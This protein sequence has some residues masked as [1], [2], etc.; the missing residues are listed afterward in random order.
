MIM[1]KQITSILSLIVLFSF[2]SCKGEDCLVI[3]KETEDIR[4]SLVDTTEVGITTRTSLNLDVN[5]FNV[6]LSR[7]E[8]QIFSNRKYKDI[9]GNTIS[10]S[11]TPGYVLTAENCNESEAESANLGW[12]QP[13]VRG[14]ETFTVIANE[15]TNVT[16]I[17][18][19]VNS[20][21]NVDFSD[22]IEDL[23]S[24]YSIEIHATDAA[25]RT[26][27]FDQSN[28][29]YKIAYFNVDESGRKLTYTVTLPSPYNTYTGTIDMESSK[30][31]TLSVKV[32]DDDSNST[33][34]LGLIVDGTLLKEEVLT[35]KINPYI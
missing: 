20:S 2:A 17:C 5:E 7:G 33:V 24:E 28:N 35:E 30:N 15:T 23:F 10:C 25:D 12:G 13:R 11:A 27:T 29:Q 22:S 14:E 32:E 19:L 31:Y 16:V 18:G 6:S 21:V 4:F 8:E 1:S 26:F 3:S 9:A 34:K